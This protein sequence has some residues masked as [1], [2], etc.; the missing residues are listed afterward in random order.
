MTGRFLDADDA[1]VRAGH[2]DIGEIGSAARQNLLV[3]GLDVR[4]RADDGGDLAVEV[5]AHRDFLGSGFRVEVD[6][7]DARALAQRFD[8]FE[9][10][11]ERDCRAPA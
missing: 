9:D 2:A 10:A 4:V 1:V 5:P 3:C 8:F 11:R 7:D 6:K